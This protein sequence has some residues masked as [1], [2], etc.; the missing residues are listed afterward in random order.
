MPPGMHSDLERDVA[1]LLDSSMGGRAW[2]VTCDVNNS[3]ARTT[4]Q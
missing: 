3:Q 2:V 1:L 4:D